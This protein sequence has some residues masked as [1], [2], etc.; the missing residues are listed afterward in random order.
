MRT[1]GLAALCLLGAL[2]GIGSA[3]ANARGSGGNADII[4]FD[5]FDLLVGP[6]G[7]IDNPGGSCREIQ[8][9]R[10][11]APASGTYYLVDDAQDFPVHCDMTLDGGGWTGV[12]GGRNGSPNVFDHFDDGAYTGTNQDP[13]GNY[14]RR[15]PGFLDQ[16]A[17]EFAV[18]CGGASVA[19]ALTEAGR[20]WLRR[21]LRSSWVPLTPRVLAGSVVNLPNSAWTGAAGNPSFIISRNQ[22]TLSNTF[23]SSY[24]GST[25]WDYCN[26]SF[27]TTSPV[28]I[29]VREPDPPPVRNTVAEARRSCAALRAEN[30]SDDGLYWLEQPPDPPYLAYCDM[31]L[32]GGGWTVAYAGRNGRAN[33]FDAFDASIHQ[34]VCPDPATRCLRRPPVDLGD[35]ATELAV[36]C[37]DAAAAFPLTTRL[38]QWLTQGVTFGWLPLQAQ[39][40]Q[41]V[42]GNLPN[43]LYSGDAG[44]PGFIVARNQ[45]A[46][47]NTFASSYAGSD[48]YSYC[49]GVNDSASMARVQYREALVAAALNEPASAGASCKSLRDGGASVDGNYWLLD[50]GGGT[51]L[52]YCDMTLDGGGWTAFHAGRNGSQNVFDRFDAGSHVGICTDPQTHCVRRMPDTVTGGEFAAACGGAFVSFPLTPAAAAYFRAGTQASWTPVSPSVIAGAVVNVPNS[53]YTGA[54]SSLGWILARNQGALSN[55]FA[56]S[57]DGNTSY[58][59][60]NGSSDSASIVRLYYREN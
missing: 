36:V 49:N 46:L 37:G 21:G 20:E 9:L 10:P 31:T 24:G 44:N 5:S 55:T 32:A 41:G 16:S 23:A 22:A 12:F 29:L 34:G 42:V 45:G 38:R 7:S 59:Y 51:I 4:Y 3:M 53:L 35:S 60:C 47:A 2:V 33:V 54:G 52:A 11:Y 50:P 28:R 56:Q 30:W 40:L 26:G 19:F 1:S 6:I 48:T 43:S 57:Y 27:D 18:T 13:V 39:S 14:L 17:A 15:A 25:S 58:D 8:R